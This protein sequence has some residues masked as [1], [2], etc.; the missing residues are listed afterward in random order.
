MESTD[1]TTH[2]LGPIQRRPSYDT[3]ESNGTQPVI[4][5]PV[6]QESVTDQCSAESLKGPYVDERWMVAEGRS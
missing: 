2:V 6:K 3:G 5:A 4:S 1:L